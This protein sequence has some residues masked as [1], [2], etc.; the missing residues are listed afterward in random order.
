LK[1]LALVFLGEAVSNVKSQCPARCVCNTTEA[2]CVD[3]SLTKFPEERFPRGLMK[4]D[5]SRNIISELGE[6]T[7]RLWMIVSLR[8]LNLSNNM[9]KR[10]NE[11][12]LMG[13][14]GLEKL[15]LSG[16]KITTIPPE[17]FM[18]ASRLQWLSL[19]N[20]REL[21]VPEDAPLLQ[22][23]SLKVL[24]LEYCNIDKISIINL[25]EV[26]ALEELYISHNKIVVITTKIQGRTW[27][28]NNIKVVDVSYNQ[29]QE[30]PPE[31]LT[32]PSLETVDVSNNKLKV[33]GEVKYPGEF[34]ER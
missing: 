8:Q 7:I 16:N 28:L 5:I 9:I 27:P 1:L 15:D 25:Q 4:L 19:A 34:C 2:S 3:S 21:E 18:Y 24:H 31:I 30:L 13:Q 32:L 12:S 22:S 26:M 14:S 29:L 17:T 6:Y 10:I 11:K 23:R 20:N 33:L